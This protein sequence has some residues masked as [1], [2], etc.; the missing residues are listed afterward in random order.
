LLCPG[1]GERLVCEPMDPARFVV[2]RATVDDLP[3]LKLLWERA[4]L[5][6]LDLE[7]HLTEFQL[8]SSLEGD[9]AGAIGLHIDGRHGL[10][11]SEA[12]AQPE[13]EDDFRQLLWDRLRNLARNFGLSHLWTQEQ[14]PFWHQQAKFNEADAEVVK[15][16]PAAFG[17]PH[18]HWSGVGLRDEAVEAKS[19]EKEFELF[20]QASRVGLD[21]V[22]S[23]TR[24]LKVGAYVIA[25]VLLFV[26]FSLV[27]YLAVRWAQSGGSLP[28]R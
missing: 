9:L 24:R 17:D 16:L 26:V 23:Q 25:G 22:L 7:R 28:P 18:R 1:S 2:R 5:Q 10:I 27:L 21:Q 19:L 14:A 15:K 6:V 11:H 20:Q 4:G 12:F 13:E 8:I 3:G